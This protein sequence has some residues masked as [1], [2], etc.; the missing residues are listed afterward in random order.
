MSKKREL[1]KKEEVL[2][3]QKKIKEIFRFFLILFLSLACLTLIGSIVYGQITSRPSNQTVCIKDEATAKEKISN[4]PEVRKYTKKLA[5][6][7]LAYFIDI[8]MPLVKGNE[9]KTGRAYVGELQE[10]NSK[11]LFNSY[12]FVTG[13]NSKIQRQKKTEPGEGNFVPIYFDYINQMA[14]K[15]YLDETRS[16]LKDISKMYKV[17]FDKDGK[18]EFL[19]GCVTGGTSNEIRYYLYKNN[20]GKIALLDMIKSS[21]EFE[22]IADF[23]KDG[24]PDM[25]TSQILMDE[26]ECKDEQCYVKTDHDPL[27]G[28]YLLKRSYHHIWNPTTSKFGDSIKSEIFYMKNGK[29]IIVKEN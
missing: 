11:S 6:D 21:G 13:C 26:G 24:Y 3:K 22:E 7:K 16:C 25:A 2:K 10:N 18:Q 17:D 23:N 27:S 19:K 15:S 1:L 12:V 5:R 14:Y 28:K 20:E 4:L 9:T 8:D 29:K